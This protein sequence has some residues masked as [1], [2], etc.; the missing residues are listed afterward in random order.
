MCR[1]CLT[2]FPIPEIST[3]ME[4]RGDWVWMPYRCPRCQ[5]GRDDW[6]VSTRSAK[7]YWRDAVRRQ[8]NVKTEADA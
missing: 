1:H 7:Y 5:R 3:K 2:V 6:Y 4:G 8:R